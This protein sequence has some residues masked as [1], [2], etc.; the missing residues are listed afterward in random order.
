[1]TRVMVVADCGTPMAT[2]TTALVRL[3]HVD[4]VR[5]ASARG[6]LGPMVRRLEPD[7]VFIDEVHWPGLILNRVAELAGVSRS[8]IYLDF[9]SRS[10]LFDAFVVDLWE[11]TGLGELGEAVKAVSARDH[12]REAIRAASVMKSQ[13]LAVYRVLHAMDRLD[14][15]SAGGAVRQMETDRRAGVQDLAEHLA[16][17]HRLGQIG[18]PTGLHRAHA[19]HDRLGSLRPATRAP[20]LDRPAGRWLAHPVVPR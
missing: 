13:E 2:L 17:R 20:G 10:G 9:G 7:L 15:E 1:M 19:E 12:L 5:H 14:P 6:P 4:I 16:G 11:R 8:T 3:E 18:Q